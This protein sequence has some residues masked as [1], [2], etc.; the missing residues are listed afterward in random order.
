VRV[1]WAEDQTM[2]RG[3][4]SALLSMEDD[5]RSVLRTSDL[6]RSDEFVMCA[7]YGWS[8]GDTKTRPW[9]PTAE[10]T[11]PICMG[12]KVPP[13]LRLARLRVRQGGDLRPNLLSTQL[14]LACFIPRGK[15]AG[16]GLK[17]FV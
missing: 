8:C 6:R 13:S 12:R 14:S 4:L 10:N 11:N 1:L 2:G 15:P 5:I 7:T 9:R 16:H 3:A 17:R